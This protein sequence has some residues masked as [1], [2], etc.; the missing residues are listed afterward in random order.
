MIAHLLHHDR[1]L[2]YLIAMNTMRVLAP[3]VAVAAC[4]II[5]LAAIGCSDTAG[6]G[7]LAI[8]VQLRFIETTPDSGYVRLNAQAFG[9]TAAS[10]ALNCTG[11]MPLSGDSPLNDSTFVEKGL[12]DQVVSET[13]TASVDDASTQGSSSTLIPARPAP[14]SFFP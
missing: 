11:F 2:K 1:H 4:G 3:A 14:Q 6:S 10:I 9:G 12:T 5:S 8:Q 7:S 13:C